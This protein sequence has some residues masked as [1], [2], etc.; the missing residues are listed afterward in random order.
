MV[1]PDGYVITSQNGGDTTL[2]SNMDSETQRTG[3]I[4]L[5]SND[6]YTWDIG[7]YILSTIGD[8]V[9]YDENKNG[10]QDEG[11]KPVEDIKVVLYESDCETA[12]SETRSD[13][14]G[15][16]SFVDLEPKE[17]C[18]GFEE[19][20]TGYQFTPN[21]QEGNNTEYDC[22]VDPGTGKT[23]PF[24]LP[25]ST[26]DNTWDMGIIPKCKDEEGRVLQVFNDEIPASTTGA[27]TTINILENDHG[28]LDIESIKFLSTT[29]GAILW[30]NG[31]AVGGTSVETSNTLVVEGEG[32]WRVNND[33]T[34]TFTAED[35]FIGVPSP[36]YYIVKC[37]QGNDSNIGQ[38]KITSNC[39]CDTVSD[40]VPTLT[41][42]SILFM[43]SSI[44]VLGLLLV[45][46][47][48][49]D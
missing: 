3:V 31:T 10:L 41:F 39:T 44:S 34:V 48:F 33:G 26:I 47:E 37:K 13:E 32:V 43:M 21:R 18:V 35:G 24:N 29:E 15:H 42:W 28:N 14:S 38:V 25:P 5:D 46:R 36:V 8:Y 9:W 6:D 1:V 49:E 4:T 27:V 11:E 22:D 23:E 7:L 19:L 20:P 45:R 30:A 17:Y 12:I 16:Y 2:D 40:S